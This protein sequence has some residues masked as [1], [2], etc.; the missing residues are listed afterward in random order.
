MKRLELVH[1]TNWKPTTISS[2]SDDPLTLFLFSELIYDIF[3]YKTLI[4]NFLKLLV[5][6]SNGYDFSFT[7]VEPQ[8]PEKV[9]CSIHGE[10]TI[11]P[12]GHRVSQCKLNAL[13]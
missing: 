4:P 11:L 7:F 2:Y 5:S 10:T 9:P 8:S 13:S 3:I 12:F 1:K 6:W